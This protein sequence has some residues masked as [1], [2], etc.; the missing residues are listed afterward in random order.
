MRIYPSDWYFSLFLVIPHLLFALL[1]T[2]SLALPMLLTLVILEPLRMGRWRLRLPTSMSRFSF[3]CALL[4]GFSL[5]FYGGLSNSSEVYLQKA[6]PS[7]LLFLLLVSVIRFR[8]YLIRRESLVNALVLLNTLIVVDLLVGE[9]LYPSRLKAVFP[10]TEISH[11]AL[12]YSAVSIAALPLVSRSVKAVVLAIGGLLLLTHPSV[13]FGVAFALIL[14]GVG[15]SLSLQARLALPVISLGLLMSVVGNSYF[16]ERLTLNDAN[17]SSL[18]YLAGLQSA[19]AG[20]LQFGIGFGFQGMGINQVSE[21]G[22]F[23]C[24]VHGFCA[25]NFDGGFMAAKMIDRS[26]L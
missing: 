18:V 25:N 14:I 15:K 5:F 3:Y 12:S 9:Q 2:S 6:I 21:I 13:T 19:S 10:F 20:V 11:F 22:L 16:L 1:G 17:L 4:L 23:L 7:V 26:G 24:S 8:L